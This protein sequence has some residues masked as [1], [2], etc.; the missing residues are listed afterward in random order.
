MIVSDEEIMNNPEEFMGDL[1][2]MGKG[3]DGE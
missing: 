1:A 2:D 3:E